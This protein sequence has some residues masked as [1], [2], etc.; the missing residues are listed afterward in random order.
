MRVESDHPG[1]Y[2]IRVQGR[3]D[4]SWSDWLGDVTV[5]FQDTPDG[6]GITTL[7]CRLDQAALR[8]LLTRLWD[9]NLTVLSV[10]SAVVPHPP[11]PEE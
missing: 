11:A 4:E 7:T 6:R 3:L 9:R 8:G 10:E 1:M 5:T 2:H